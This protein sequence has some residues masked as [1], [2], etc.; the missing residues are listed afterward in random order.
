MVGYPGMGFTGGEIALPNQV[1]FCSGH[2][3]NKA[4]CHNPVINVDCIQKAREEQSRL[5]AC[6]EVQNLAKVSWK[7][8]IEKGR[9]TK[10]KTR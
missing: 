2:G 10:K 7:L 4:C 6:A 8:E 3:P 9:G 5:E 1:P